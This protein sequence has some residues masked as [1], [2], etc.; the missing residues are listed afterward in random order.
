M[1]IDAQTKV[2]IVLDNSH[3]TD[4]PTLLDVGSQ[5]PKFIHD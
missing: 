3:E 2:K 5:P 4:F 1:G